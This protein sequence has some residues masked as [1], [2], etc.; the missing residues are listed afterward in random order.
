VKFC[1]DFRSVIRFC[2]TLLV[3]SPEP[4]IRDP[5]GKND[6]DLLPAFSLKVLLLPYLLGDLA[7]P[8]P[9][10]V[11]QHAEHTGRGK[12][13]ILSLDHPVFRPFSRL[14][15]DVSTFEVHSLTLKRGQSIKIMKKLSVTL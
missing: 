10:R 2:L 13:D 8:A 5:L 12:I 15:D 11:K 4:D 1:Q 3:L 6:K 7:V 9:Y 14:M